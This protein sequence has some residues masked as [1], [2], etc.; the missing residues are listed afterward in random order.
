MSQ[1]AIRD[2]LTSKIQSIGL[3]QPIMWPN[4]GNFTTPTNQIWLRVTLLFGDKFQLS[5]ADSDELFGVVSIGIFTPKGSG[6]KTAYQI[7]DQL[8]TAFSRLNPIPFTGGKI[9]I[10]SVEPARQTEDEP[11]HVIQFRASFRAPVVKL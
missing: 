8:D 4:Q 9:F 11:W 3:T 1:T 6:T 2:A 5:L 7:C 10:Q